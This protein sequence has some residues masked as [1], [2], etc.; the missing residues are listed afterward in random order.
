MEWDDAAMAEAAVTQRQA[1]LE[2]LAEEAGE[3]DE[4]GS[5]APDPDW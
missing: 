5:D 4:W 3:P 2:W 1:Y